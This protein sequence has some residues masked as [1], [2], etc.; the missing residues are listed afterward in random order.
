MRQKRKVGSNVG[1][2]DICGHH[3]GPCWG[4]GL[5]RIG[6][7]SCQADKRFAD[8]GFPKVRDIT[9]PIYSL[10]M[11]DPN[12]APFAPEVFSHEASMTMMGFVLAAQKAAAVQFLLVQ[13]LDL[14]FRH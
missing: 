12:V 3:P 14:P 6:H 10:E 9:R 7:F 4:P 8:V 1:M 5:V 13:F 11:S 2:A